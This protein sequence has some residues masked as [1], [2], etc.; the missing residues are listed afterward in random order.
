MEKSP[1]P[2]KQTLDHSE[3]FSGEKKKNSLPF[4]MSQGS[5]LKASPDPRQGEEATRAEKKLKKH[6]RKKAQDTTAC[7]IPDPWPYKARDAL[8]GCTVGKEAEEQAALGQKWKQGSSRE[9]SGKERKEEEARQVEVLEYIPIRD[10]PKAPVK[11]KTK[12]K[13]K[14]EQPVVEELAQKRKKKKK[15][16]NVVAADPL[17]E[18]PD[19]DLEVVLEKKGN[20]SEVHIDQWDTAGFE[21]KEQKLKFLKPMSGFKNLYPSFRF[22]PGMTTRPNMALSKTAG[23]IPQ[24][25]LRQDYDQAMSW[26]YSRGTGL[27][28]SATPNKV[29]YIDRNASRSVRLED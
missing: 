4:A 3:S 23:D 12:A 2:R 10:D 6:E 29:L 18:E 7:P 16:A 21:S 8:Y 13:K 1:N 9:H 22:P 17:K 24:Q 19:T 14:V 15:K 28:F 27:D 26:K 5:G 11:K 20:M 25:N